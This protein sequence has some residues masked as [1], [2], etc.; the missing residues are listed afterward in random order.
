[1]NKLS[2]LT[3]YKGT[4]PYAS[5]IFGVY[6]P[7][8]GWKS[9]RKAKRQK[10]SGNPHTGKVI[11]ELLS[12]YKGRASISFN[13]DGMMELGG[14]GPGEANS[15]KLLP[16]TNSIV[17]K[18]ISHIISG[19]RPGDEAQWAEILN[20]DAMKT[21]LAEVVFPEIKSKC[22]TRVMNARAIDREGHE[23]ESEF[24][25]RVSLLL[26]QSQEIAS[27]ALQS[28]SAIAGM[29][30]DLAKDGLVNPLNELFYENTGISAQAEIKRISKLI[31]DGFD[32]PFSTFDPRKGLKNVTVSPLGIVHLY[33]QFFFELDTFLGTP[34]GHVWMSPGSTVELIEVNTRRSITEKSFETEYESLLKTERSLTEQDEIS[35]AVKEDNKSDTKVGFSTTVTSSY[36]SVSVSAT[37]SLGMDKTQQIAREEAHKRMRQQTEKL[38][39]EIRQNYKSTFKTITE[40]TDTSS[41]RYLLTNPTDELINY[42]LR[43]KMRKVA[44]QVQ[45]MGTYLCWETFVDE[46]GKELGLANLIHVAQPPE[47][48]GGQPL[49]M[50]PTPEPVLLTTFNETLVWQMGD[51]QVWGDS[52]SMINLKTIPVPA[53]PQPGYELAFHNNNPVFDIGQ[54]S[55]S[56][57][58]RPWWFKAEILP[59]KTQIRIGV[60]LYNQTTITE[61]GR[62]DFEVTG[63][64]KWVPSAKLLS[65]IALANEK[66]AGDIEKAS[67]EKVLKEKEAFV[68]AARDR[69]TA[70]SKIKKRN[71]EDLR[72][73][74]RIIIYRKLIESLMTSSNYNLPDTEEHQE[75]RHVLSELIKSIFDIDKML[76]FVAPEWWKARKHY[77]QSIL[78]STKG[79]AGNGRVNPMAAKINLQIPLIKHI[80]PNP[81][82]TELQTSVTNWSGQESREDNYYITEESNPAPLGSSLGW[83]LQLDGDNHRNSF[84]NSPWVKAVIPIRP[85]KELAAINW[86]KNVE[87]EGADGLDASYAGTEEELA[88]I[89]SVLQTETPDQPAQ[90]PPSLNDAIRVLCIDVAKKNAES[91]KVGAFPKDPGIHDDDKVNCTPIEKVYEHGFYP[92]QGGFRANPNPDEPTDPNADPNN[93]DRYFT[94]I[95]QWLEILPTDQIVPVKV[96]YNPATGQL[97]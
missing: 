13:P 66:T 8:I 2:D 78:P 44:V 88:T 4:L 26:R 42:E 67:Q 93:H 58:G 52:K 80:S 71:F 75:S 29:L 84:L 96:A 5:E 38:S 20:P 57:G 32:D 46:P 82:P 43:R 91:L 55:N 27:S 11:S 74:E 39:S 50:I 70:A 19:S 51:S 48:T 23:S 30:I 36:P 90:V 72:E 85:G 60:Y 89:S 59:G 56:R 21:I 9:S 24:Q 22:D 64:L 62:I 33:R 87:V 40:V 94:I 86:L 15:G 10:D 73:E 76:Y 34:T 65:D 68:K 45:D 17:L 79:A 47:M 95:S 63:T 7:L 81:I 83:L 1:M 69:V 35:K 18:H 61:E 54:V 25:E 3:K 31:K 49:A 16:Q 92:L 37:A 41:K 53:P 28:E 6:Q 14:L 12:H 77:H 97:L